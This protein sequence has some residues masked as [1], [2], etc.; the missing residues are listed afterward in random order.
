LSNLRALKKQGKLPLGQA[1]IVELIYGT[2][3]IN[4]NKNLTLRQAFFASTEHPKPTTSICIH[5]REP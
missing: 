1:G 5:K 4:E 3:N 2:L